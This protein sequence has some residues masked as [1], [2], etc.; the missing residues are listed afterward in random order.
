MSQLNEIITQSALEPAE[1]KTLA[2]KF[3]DYE[4]IAEDWERKARAIVVTDA[5]QKAEMDMA[6]AGRKHMASLRIEVEKTR[7]ALKEQSL[8]KGQAIDAIARWLTSLIKPTEDYLKEQERF[9]EIQAAKK[10]EEERLK[11]EAKAEAERIAREKAEAEEQA[12]IRAE[13]EKLK[14]EAE[15]R[16]RKAA[17]ERAEAE[18]LLAAE[19]AKAEAERKA[20]AAAAAEAEAKLRQLEAEKA[21]MICCPA[22]GHKFTIEG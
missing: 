14:K 6:A 4:A 2:E 8:R 5:S 3:K 11:A 13:N 19:K 1:Q 22:C 9:V 20:A 10:D 17:A 12:R 7:K 18:R 15:E 16:E 21:S